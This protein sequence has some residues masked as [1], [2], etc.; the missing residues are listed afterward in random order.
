M[1]DAV[2][3]DV[4]A[5]FGDLPELLTPRIRLRR[6]KL[7]DADD[8]FAY[9]TDPEV[10]RHTSWQ[11]HR[12]IEESREL[13]ARVV[14]RYERGEVANWGVEHRLD[15]RFIGTAGYMRWDVEDRR[16]EVGYAMAP[17]YWGQGLMTEAL[18]AIIAFG[19]E[20]MQLNRIEARCAAEN[21]GSYRVMEKAGMAF[22]GTLRE[23]YVVDGAFIDI[24]LYSILRRE[25]EQRG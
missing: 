16:A 14:G 8:L 24:K 5:V 13:L 21:S 18:G 7:D 11:P 25:Y 9:A 15:G 23:R 17:A 6:M 19:F 4:L 3:P 2:R 22:E 10:T 20:Q 1:G 12:S